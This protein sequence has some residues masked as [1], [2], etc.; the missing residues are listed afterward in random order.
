MSANASGDGRP[1]IVVVGSINMDLVLRCDR[2]PT[3]GETISADSCEEVCGGKG[4]NQAVAAA[5]AGGD[6]HMIG[7]VGVDSF[8]TRL[9]RNLVEQG[10]HCDA[11]TTT[12][13]CPSGLA[14]IGVEA[15]G[16][17]Q[18]TVVAGANGRLT[19]SDVRR[20]AE[21]IQSADVLMV[22]WEVPLDTVACAI[23]IARHAGVRCVLDPAPV[24]A[25]WTDAI[26]NVDVLCPNETE[27]S[28]IT[29]HAITNVS[30]CE[31]AAR[32][33]H[34]RGAQ[35]V[36]ITMGRHGCGLLTEGHF[37]HIPSPT[38]DAVD[39]TAAGDAFAGA[40]AVRWSQ[41]DDLVDAVRFAVIAGALATT[42]HG[43]QSSLFHR[44]EIESFRSRT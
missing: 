15:S 31:S 28:A 33:L 5:L 1:R 44:T 30:H 12:D 19:P 13:D 11:V 43:A 35:H 42:R 6:V 17:N 40:L 7:R 4:A 2:L 34:K 41:T 27:A 39:T 22:Q 3:A 16:Q 21:L 29:G 26:L 23:E 20:D 9:R 10:V 32:T 36:A 37:H 38:V 24:A 8:A 25:G 14:I 18:I